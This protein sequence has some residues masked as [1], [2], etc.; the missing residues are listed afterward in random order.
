MRKVAG[1][2][3]LTKPATGKAGQMLAFDANTS[4]LVFLATFLESVGQCGG[5]CHAQ[6]LDMEKDPAAGADRISHS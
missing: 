5:L 1:V 6:A 4:L 2:I 3:E